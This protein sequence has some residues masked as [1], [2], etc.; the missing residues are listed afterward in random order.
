MISPE[1]VSFGVINLRW[2]GL[3]IALGM[4]AAYFCICFRAKRYGLDASKCADL[5]FVGMLCGLIGA[6]IEYVRREFAMF[7]GDWLRVFKI[8]EGGI[9]FQGGLV[10]AAAAIVV[11]CLWR[12]WRVGDVGDLCAPALAIGHAFGRV[13]C[14]LNGC[15]YGKAHEG[16]LAVHYPNLDGGVLAIQGLEAVLCLAIAAFLLLIEWRKE[17]RGRLFPLYL[18]IYSI[19]RFFIEFGRGD[20]IYLSPGSFTP[21]QNLFVFVVLPV[22]VI[23]YLAVTLLS[24]R[25]TSRQRGK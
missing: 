2:Y 9:S 10:L 16:F 5:V 24:S 14:L 8:W 17:Q 6:R 4:L 7:S 15:C 13:G 1:I 22:G 21:A 25:Q 11:M 18:I 19:G 12:K 20:Y 23:W 3:C